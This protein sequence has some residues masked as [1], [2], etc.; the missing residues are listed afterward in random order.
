MASEHISPIDLPDF[1]LIANLL[2]QEGVFV[3]SPSELHGLFC[4][5]LAAGAR[6]EPDA[7]LR[8]ACDLMDVNSLSQESSKVGLLALYQA[9]LAQL[10]A[11][12]F[13]FQLLLPDDEVELAQRVQMLANW[14]TGFLSGFGLHGQHSDASLSA[15]TRETL[16]DLGQIAQIALDVEETDENEADLM[17]VQEYVRMGCL[18]VFTECNGDRSDDDAKPEPTV[19]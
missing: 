16:N 8:I 15:E 7:L 11:T 13:S 14:C 9:S 5:H 19:H 12:D 1:D 4:G 6:M 2:V 10:Q 3:V 17:E 18:M